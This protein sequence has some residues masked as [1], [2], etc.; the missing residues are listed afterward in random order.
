MSFNQRTINYLKSYFTITDDEV[1][2]CKDTVKDVCQVDVDKMTCGEIGWNHLKLGL[3]GNCE[4]KDIIIDKANGSWN[5]YDRWNYKDLNNIAS[6]M[7]HNQLNYGSLLKN[8]RMIQPNFLSMSIVN[9]YIIVGESGG[10]VNI[11]DYTSGF[12]IN[13]SQWSESSIT[14][15]ATYSQDDK[16]YLFVGTGFGGLTLCEFSDDI[17]KLNF[18]QSDYL[19]CKVSYGCPCKNTPP[20]VKINVLPEKDMVVVGLGD[21]DRRDGLTHHIVNGTEY[22]D[23]PDSEY[24]S[25]EILVFRISDKTLLHRLVVPPFNKQ[26][27]LTKEWKFRLNDIDANEKSIIGSYNNGTIV[28]WSLETQQPTMILS[29]LSVQP[30]II[31]F[32]DSDNFYYTGSNSIYKDSTCGSYTNISDYKIN[33]VIHLDDSTFIYA[34]D[35]TIK[36]FRNDT[37]IKEFTDHKGKVTKLGIVE[38][39]DKKVLVSC[40]LEGE[41]VCWNIDEVV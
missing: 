40:S 30:N 41:L 20:I 4:R 25:N 34:T 19:N 38:V 6:Q 17:M 35:K 37:L 15:L 16:N 21:Y 33:D 14:S 8:C 3:T 22:E 32:I 5:M 24:K 1:V 10:E 11:F 29:N 31:K 39:S 2:F 13:N 12:Q 28:K 23:L 26:T 7:N 27:P 36:V 18:K 9:K